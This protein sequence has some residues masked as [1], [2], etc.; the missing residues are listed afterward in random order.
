MTEHAP[1][2]EELRRRLE[3]G[4]PNALGELFARYRD[5]LRRMVAVRLDRRL[6]GR[7][8]PSDV[9]Q[10][11]YAEATA[12]LPEYLRGPE[13]APYLWLRLLTAQKLAQL[14]RQHLGVQARAA[15]R[16]VALDQAA[17]ACAEG[18]AALLV[19]ESS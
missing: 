17:E 14:H 16:E 11:A 4:D 18:M 5:P 3:S 12:R 9:I 10:E 15:A 8:D 7:I 19:D 2:P 1:D 6:Q 13:M